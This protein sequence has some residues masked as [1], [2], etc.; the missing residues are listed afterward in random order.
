[1]FPLSVPYR[2]IIIGIVSVLILVSIYV[3]GHSDGCNSV[4]VKFDAYK[5]EVVKEATIQDAKNTV[6][7]K[8]QAMINKGASDAY[9]A[10]LSAVNN[11]YHGVRYTTS[12]DPVSSISLSPAGANASPSYPVL[13]GQCAQTTLQLTTLQQWIKDNQD[14]SK[15]IS[16]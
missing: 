5:E 1:M 15:E 12:G 3:K 10:N 16:K 13:I 14:A 11:Y 7:I 2:N 9:K 4:Q 8:Q 6:L